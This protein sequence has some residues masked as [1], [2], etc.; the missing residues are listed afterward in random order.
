M[1]HKDELEILMIE[2][3]IDIIFINETKLDDTL[4]D[5]QVAIEVFLLLRFDRNR[6]GGG[7]AFYIRETVNKTSKAE[8]LCI[9]VKQKCTKPFVVMAWYRLPK[10]EYQTTDEIDTLCRYQFDR[11]PSP[12]GHPGAFALKCVPSPGAFAQQKMPGGWANKG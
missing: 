11:L 3:K 5:K 4:R 8:L 10:Y 9:E 6:H 12:P 1:K 2:N 7:V